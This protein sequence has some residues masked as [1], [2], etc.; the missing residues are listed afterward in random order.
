MGAIPAL[1]VIASML[2]GSV[3][4]H[5]IPHRRHFVFLHWVLVL[6]QLPRI[7]MYLVFRMCKKYITYGANYGPSWDDLN[8]ESL[9]VHA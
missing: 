1:A 4:M 8:L 9:V 2:H 3:A 7:M 6:V 5:R